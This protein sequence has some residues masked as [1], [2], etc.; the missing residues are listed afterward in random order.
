[1]Q[2]NI[3]ILKLNFQEKTKTGS[4]EAEPLVI[5][6]GA[7]QLEELRFK[8]DEFAL[9]NKRPVVWIF[10]YGNLSMRKARSQ[11]AN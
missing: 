3:L 9:S 6:R 7:E 10:T 8:T 2:L 4:A 5:Y 11:F 1:M